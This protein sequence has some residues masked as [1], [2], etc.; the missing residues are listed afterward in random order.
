V[1]A[2]GYIGNSQKTGLSSNNVG[3][4]S[5]KEKPTGWIL[6]THYTFANNTLTINPRNTIP[7]DFTDGEFV[8]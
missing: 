4:I 1:T 8:F 5:L 7:E 2:T 3:I 6:N